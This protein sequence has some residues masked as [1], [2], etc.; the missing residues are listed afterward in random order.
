MFLMFGQVN[1]FFQLELLSSRFFTEFDDLTKKDYLIVYTGKELMNI[2]GIIDWF[3]KQPYSTLL[4][5]GDSEVYAFYKDKEKKRRFGGPVHKLSDTVFHFA[6]S[7]VYTVN[8]RKLL[9]ANIGTAKVI[10]D[11]DYHKLCISHFKH[12][13]VS[14][15]RNGGKVDLVVSVVPPHKV[16][17]KFYSYAQTN[18]Y[19]MYMDEVCRRCEFDDW[20]FSE[21]DLDIDYEKYHSVHRSVIEIDGKILTDYSD[22]ELDFGDNI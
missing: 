7:G 15:D 2:N 21:F 6:N 10:Y 18:I 22:V 14:I 4:L 16:S 19:H 3:E 17:N 12:M 5:D 11:D 13:L 9:I 8:R 1:S 20:Y